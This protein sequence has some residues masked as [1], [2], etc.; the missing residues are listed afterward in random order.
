MS[1]RAERLAR[2]L[3]DEGLPAGT[4]GW[5]LRQELGDTREVRRVIK[6]V[7]KHHPPTTPRGG[8]SAHGGES[9]GDDEAG[10]VRAN[11]KRRKAQEF[12]CLG[13][14]DWLFGYLSDNELDPHDAPSNYLEEWAEETGQDLPED[15]LAQDLS[16]EDLAA[17]REWLV[18]NQ[19][20]AHFVE[21][22]PFEAPA[23]LMLDDPKKMPPGTWCVH[24]TNAAPFHAFDRGA[25][26]QGLHLS[27]WRKEKTF[28]DCKKNLDWDN[29]GIY[30]VVFGFAFTANSVSKSSLFER[31]R[32]KYGRNAILFQVDC[33]VEA[34]HHGDEERQVIWPLCAEKNLVAFDM[35]DGFGTVAV[36]DEDGETVFFDKLDDLIKEIGSR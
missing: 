28:V 1:S 23:Y 14:Q 19:K 25:T 11:G 29:V 31:A 15:A 8:W 24:F 4:I 6:E 21:H 16:D 22:D 35:I 10:M 3:E 7:A 26:L 18:N 32:R 33:G 9:A 5:L 17:Y 36:Q 2:E 13:I 20:G 34:Y 12:V 30:D 27:T